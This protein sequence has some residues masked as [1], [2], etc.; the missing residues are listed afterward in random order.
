MDEEIKQ[1]LIDLH[2]KV[3]D[4]AHAMKRCLNGSRFRIILRVSLKNFELILNPLQTFQ[5]IHCV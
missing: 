2:T 4:I 1:S 5:L 3:D